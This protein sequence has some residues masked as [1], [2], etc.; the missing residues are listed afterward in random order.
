MKAPG[1]VQL[2]ETATDG[3]LWRNV[4][5]ALGALY[6]AQ[7]Y[8]VEPGD[9]LAT[10]ASADGF[11]LKLRKDEH[12]VL[13]QCTQAGAKQLPH[14]HV[15]RLLG[16]VVKQGAT[17]AV[18][19]T[20][21][22]FT[23]YARTSAAK[24]GHIQ[25]IDGTQMQAMLGSACTDFASASVALPLAALAIG[26]RIAAVATSAK[27]GGPALELASPLVPEPQVQEIDAEKVEAVPDPAPRMLAAPDVDAMRQPARADTPQEAVA[28]AAQVKGAA[29]R[30]RARATGRKAATP[31]SR[32]TKPLAGV[33][34][35]AVAMWTM[36]GA[37]GSFETSHSGST[38]AAAKTLPASALA[39]ASTPI[40]ASAPETG[41]PA[42]A[43]VAISASTPAQPIDNAA[44]A[45]AGTLPVQAPGASAA[46]ASTDAT[47]AIIAAADQTSAVAALRTSEPA[48]V[49]AVDPTTAAQ[50]VSAGSNHPVRVEVAAI[51]PRRAPRRGAA[52]GIDD[53][54]RNH[55][56]RN[57]EAM[58]VLEKNTPAIGYALP[59]H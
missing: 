17:A 37:M 24:L 43:A 25:L 33:L 13:V 1:N 47:L 38:L 35:C 10:G 9:T 55:E 57:A 45:N 15:H 21:G 34:A 51:S 28:A 23:D 31:S 53:D 58:R 22:E 32:L 40:A 7:G 42:S 12:I 44:E 27:P 39:P 49:E 19:V 30:F 26:P 2:R 6:R 5:D 29:A 18:L 3:P 16:A 36:Q 11:D 48:T 8:A 56:R 4:V 20:D 14:N 52:N 41:M 46:A 50:P 54:V 59:N